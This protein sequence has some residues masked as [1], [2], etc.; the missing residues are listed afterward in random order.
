MYHLRPI[1]KT[2]AAAGDDAR[3]SEGSSEDMGKGQKVLLVEDNEMNRQ[4]MIALMDSLGY[5]LELAEDGSVGV[6][7]YKADGPYDLVLM[8]L[9]M[10]NMDGFEAA[11][12][13]RKF[14]TDNEM[15]CTPII[16]MTA[17]A[18]EKEKSE[19]KKWG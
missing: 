8:D 7:R 10:P 12:N 16:T 13:I 18:L 9:Q 11:S 17:N 15:E 3:E 2:K 5:D 1:A 4:V 14:E 19:V 6:Q